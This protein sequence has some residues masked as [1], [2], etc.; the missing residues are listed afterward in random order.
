MSGSKSLKSQALGI[1]NAVSFM[2]SASGLLTALS[3]DSRHCL[4]VPLTIVNAVVI[5]AKLLFG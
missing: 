3:P 4:P 5:V 2:R 1:H